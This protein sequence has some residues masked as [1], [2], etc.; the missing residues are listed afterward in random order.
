MCLCVCLCVC[1]PWQLLVWGVCSGKYYEQHFSPISLNS[2]ALLPNCW[3][4]SPP[5][6]APSP[7]PAP[8][9]TQHPLCAHCLNQQYFWK[10]V[11]QSC[12]R[13][14]SWEESCSPPPSP[15]FLLLLLLFL[16]CPIFPR[17]LSLAQKDY[18]VHVF[19]RLG[20]RC[21]KYLSLGA[22]LIF[23]KKK[24]FQCNPP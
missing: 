5:P 23:I 9:E 18:T 17:S 10:L 21:L 4:P 3:P 22:G 13:Q 6:P 15:L 1:A 12:L 2:E 16:I 20:V 19:A 14:S 8:L 7:P 11:R 24:H